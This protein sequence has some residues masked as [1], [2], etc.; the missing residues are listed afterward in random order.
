MNLKKLHILLLMM[1]MILLVCIGSVSAIEN[2]ESNVDDIA[3][4]YESSI[5]PTLSNENNAT[6]NNDTNGTQ[7]NSEKINT[8]INAED[9]EINSNDSAKINI[10]VKDNESNKLNITKSDLNVSENNKT[11]A[12]TFKNSTITILSDLNIG[13]HNIIITYLGNATYA[14]S[15]TNISI[16]IRSRSEERRVGKECRS[17]WSP[18]H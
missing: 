8:E 14:N 7:N 2:N 9:I 15:S 6:N 5:S 13:E 11:L 4:D 18:Y 1:C 16:K 10:S 3:T 12:F 17:R